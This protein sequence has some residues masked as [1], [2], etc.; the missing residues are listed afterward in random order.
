[1]IAKKL[2][3]LKFYF[4][5]SNMGQEGFSKNFSLWGIYKF[6]LDLQLH[7]ILVLYDLAHIPNWPTHFGYFWKQAL[8]VRN[9]QFISR[10]KKLASDIKYLV[11]PPKNK[12]FT[13]TDFI[14]LW[15]LPSKGSGRSAGYLPFLAFLALDH[16]NGGP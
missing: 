4:I 3:F 7:L 12:C 1:M 11:K 14:K 2:F 8:I 15:T 16:S 13:K 6:P 9:S 10:V 5:F